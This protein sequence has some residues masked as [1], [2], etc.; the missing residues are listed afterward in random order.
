MFHKKGLKNVKLSEKADSLG[1]ICC[2]TR[3]IGN[4]IGTLF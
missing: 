2:S 4:L 3:S 1:V